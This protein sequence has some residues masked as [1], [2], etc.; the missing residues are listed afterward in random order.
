MITA[1]CGAMGK[2][3]SC[4]VHQCLLL[5]VVLLGGC[6]CRLVFELLVVDVV[7]GVVLP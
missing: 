3:F 5:S 2:K 7:F 1:L 4:L 6:L